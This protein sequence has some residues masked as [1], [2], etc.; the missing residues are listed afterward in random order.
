MEIEHLTRKSLEDIWSLYSTWIE[1]FVLLFIL[2]FCW[3]LYHKRKRAAEFKSTFKRTEDLQQEVDAIQKKMIA[4][5]KLISLGMLAAGIAHEI[6][7][8]LNFIQNFSKLSQ[9][10]CQELDTLIRKKEVGETENKEICQIVES[11]KENLKK[12]AEH[13]QRANDIIQSILLHSRGEIHQRCQVKLHPI[14]DEAI[15]LSYH[16]LKAEDNTFNVKI[17]T[18]YDPLID[19]IDAV[20]VEISRVLVNLLN[21]SFYS[22]EEKKKEFKEQFIPELTIITLKS[23]DSI[24]ITIRDN[25]KGIPKDNINKIFTPFFTTKPLDKGNGLGLPLSREV[26]EEYQGR[27]EVNSQ[28]GKF[29][30]FSIT[31]PITRLK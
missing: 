8:P 19:S 18:Q 30:E 12:I 10:L 26:I 21:N 14:I 11:L 4:H 1:G 23:A 16:A 13:S 3:Q 2:F 27:L 22:L 24:K 5:H 29:A 28:E 31:L 7:N 9:D 6:K 25:G 17:T 20:S 15:K